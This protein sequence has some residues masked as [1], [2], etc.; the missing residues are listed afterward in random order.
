M[1]CRRVRHLDWRHL[2]V[3][4]EDQPGEEEAEEDLQHPEAAVVEEVEEEAS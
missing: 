1:K 3:E 4:L 2:V